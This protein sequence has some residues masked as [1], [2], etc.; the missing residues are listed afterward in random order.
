[1]T[2]IDLEFAIVESRL[3]ETWEALAIQ[4]TI[5]ELANKEVNPSLNSELNRY[6]GFWRAIN[7]SLQATIFT[8][9][10]ALLDE[11]SSDSATFYSIL[12]HAERT[13]RHVALSG[14]ASRLT[15]MRTKYKIPPKRLAPPS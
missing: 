6:S 9:L 13:N 1:M 4:R 12:R 3:S 2:T 15:E 11:N 10:F 7:M 14:M 5:N 8:G